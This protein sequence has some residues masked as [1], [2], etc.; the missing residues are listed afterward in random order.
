MNNQRL[1]WIDFIKF[2]AI[3][4]VVQIHV[5]SPLIYMINQ[6]SPLYW[7]IAN[8]FDSLARSA[9]P[10]FFMVSGYLLFSKKTDS[11]YQ[12]YLKKISRVI[13]PLIAWSL[14]YILY[15]KFLLKENL[16]IVEHLFYSIFREEYYHL[17]FMYAIVGIYLSFPIIY[18]F[19]QNASENLVK[20]F[21]LIWVITVSIFPLI[22]K[23][24][25]LEY[26]NYLP[27]YTGYIGYVILGYKL[28]NIE[29]KK[30]YF[31]S[32]FIIFLLSSF[33]VY[34]TTSILSL[35]NLLFDGFF[36]E[37]FSIFVLIQSISCFI[38][39]KSF[40]EFFTIN[41]IL[42]KLISTVSSCVLGIYLIHPIIIDILRSKA[43]GIKISAIY[44]N[45][46]YM[47]PIT[48]TIVFVISFVIVYFLRKIKILRIILP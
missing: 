11:F 44:G 15:K 5:S 47:I 34:Y 6:T 31:F 46:I 1:L 28:G 13:I 41:L 43:I 18:Y 40:M 20:M 27:I 19:V 4:F 17:W 16:N 10:L 22:T 25:N 23:F 38:L 32:S 9:V 42:T 33:L 12:F 26:T 24:L 8:A 30:Y 29:L 7:N 39:I 35:K 2:I 3:I 45:P 48:I 37:N 21:L 14:I 36:Y